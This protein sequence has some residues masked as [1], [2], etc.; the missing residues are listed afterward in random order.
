[1]INEIVISIVTSIITAYSSYLV[2]NSKR[3]LEIKIEKYSKVMRLLHRIKM[4]DRFFSDEYDERQSFPQD[5]EETKEWNARREKSEKYYCSEKY[6]NEIRCHDE[7]RK[8]AFEEISKTI[9]TSL[10]ILGDDIISILIELQDNYKHQIDFDRLDD[11]IDENRKLI[12]TCIKRLKRRGECEFSNFP[13][14]VIKWISS[15]L[16]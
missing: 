12:D 3:W 1:M 6:K 13:K 11:Q 2:F 15:L 9:D 16:C 4:A 5:N 7:S 8:L 14:R 10:F